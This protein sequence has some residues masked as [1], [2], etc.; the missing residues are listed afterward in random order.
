MKIKSGHAFKFTNSNRVF[1]VVGIKETDRGQKM[2]RWESE[3]GWSGR[4][5]MDEFLLQCKKGILN[6]VSQNK[7]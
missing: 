1:K 5:D 7:S 6:D 2:V 4:T 3:D